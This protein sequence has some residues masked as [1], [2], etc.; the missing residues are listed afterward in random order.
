MVSSRH[1][2][3][4]FTAASPVWRT[5]DTEY[6]KFLRSVQTI[7]VFS[8]RTGSSASRDVA[9]PFSG[10]S[11]CFQI[12]TGSQNCNPIASIPNYSHFSLG[13]QNTKNW[14]RVAAKY[15]LSFTS[16]SNNGPS[17]KVK[18]TRTVP[19]MCHRSIPW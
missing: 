14:E 10:D 16:T 5:F 12:L 17:T 2:N 8:R 7:P 13:S 18:E 19:W 9:D 11:R 6:Y 1:A 3:F 15:Y 4:D